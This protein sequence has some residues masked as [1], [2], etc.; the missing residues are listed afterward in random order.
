MYTRDESYD[1]ITIHSIEFIRI[2]KN[3]I[4]SRNKNKMLHEKSF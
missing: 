4:N 1:T 3:A 2:N